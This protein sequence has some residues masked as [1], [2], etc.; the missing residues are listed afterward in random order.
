MN[1]QPP[2]EESARLAAAGPVTS[3]ERPRPSATVTT[4]RNRG[5]SAGSE[6]RRPEAA[7][8][9]ALCRAGRTGRGASGRRGTAA[10]TCP[11]Q[12][13]ASRQG[14]VGVQSWGG[15]TARGR[16]LGQGGG[17]GDP[18]SGP[19]PS[20]QCWEWPQKGPVYP[21]YSWADR[22]GEVAPTWLQPS[23][24]GGCAL[25]GEML[26][27]TSRPPEPPVG[28]REWATRGGSGWGAEWTAALGVQ[29]GE[30]VGRRPP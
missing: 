13:P 3:C 29:C 24:L 26:P 22:P 23:A 18:G 30:E 10:R 11:G 27:P 7:A 9:S 15:H 20:S 2:R 28:Q 12:R 19:A 6:G 8:P 4:E 5:L 1:F 25:V 16:E 14:Q 17:S 21:G